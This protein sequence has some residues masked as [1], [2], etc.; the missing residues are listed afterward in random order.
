MKKKYFLNTVNPYDIEIIGGHENYL[1]DVNGKQYLDLWGDEGVSPLGASTC[2][3]NN[4]N[5]FFSQCKTLHIPKMYNDP[6]KEELAKKLVEFV[7]WEDG[8]VFFSNSGTEAMETAIKMARLYHYK[9]REYDFDIFT[10]EGN[11]H[12]R[13][14]FSLAASDSSDSPYHKE[15]FG[16]MPL[17]FRK[18]NDP[19]EYYD[20]DGICAITMATMLGNNKIVTYSNTFMNKIMKLKENTGALL[21]LD[22]IQ[23]GMGRTGECMAFHHYNNLE[24]DIIAVG[25]GMAMG[26]PLSATIVKREIAE[27]MT[28][29]THFCTTGGNSL[30]CNLSIKFIDW[31][32]EN[33]DSI[34]GKGDLLQDGLENLSFVK[35]VHGLGLHL[36]IE[37]D[38][39]KYGYDGFDFCKNAIKEGLLIC[40]HRKYGQIRITPP[41]SITSD[42]IKEVLMKLDK[43]HTV[44]AN[45]NLKL[46]ASK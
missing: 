39:E 33:L 23:V 14:G 44:T 15:G 2:I 18:F 26:L 11:F 8:M 17:G 29:G 40:T 34:K 21:I 20:F 1:F 5:L 12:G 4:I 43:I 41:L 31:L 30:A 22:E 36:S 27:V 35:F 7:G 37:I 38:F 10:L 9:K 24:P 19:E 3:D 16:P 46:G 42:Q 45:K 6:I 32:Y 13:T 25:K 28:P